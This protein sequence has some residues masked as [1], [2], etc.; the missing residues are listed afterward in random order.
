MTQKT[1]KLNRLRDVSDSAL[2]KLSKKKIYFG[3]QSVGNNIVD[4]IS[5]LMKENP[6]I[7]LNILK[8][9]DP[10]YTQVGFFAHSSFL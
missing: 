2:E 9:D 1:I 5:D 7:K 3:H 10:D 8:T 4:G 6:G